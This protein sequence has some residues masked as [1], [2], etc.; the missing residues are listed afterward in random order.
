[1]LSLTLLVMANP[2]EEASAPGDMA[3]LLAVRVEVEELGD[4]RGQH[5]AIE[6]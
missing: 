1:M 5:T 3:K 2:I 4:F 6:E